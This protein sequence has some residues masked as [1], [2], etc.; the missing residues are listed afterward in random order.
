MRQSHASPAAFL[1]ARNSF[2]IGKAPATNPRTSSPHR[3]Q[4]VRVAV[5]TL[6]RNAWNVRNFASGAISLI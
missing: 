6:E 3:L 4:W 1:S 5:G 2:A